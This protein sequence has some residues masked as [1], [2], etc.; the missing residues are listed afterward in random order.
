MQ[1]DILP[2]TVPVRASLSFDLAPLRAL[3]GDRCGA[4][5]HDIRQ[6]QGGQSNPTFLLFTDKGEYVLRKQPGGAL[7]PSA[8]AIDREYRIIEAL[9]HTDVPVPRPILYCNDRSV[10]GTPFYIME[11]LKGRG[12]A[13]PDL[14]EIG[15]AERHAIYEGMVDALAKLHRADWNALGLADYGK[16]E[17]YYARQISRWTKQ[18]NA[19][20]TRDN[21]SIDRLAEWLP[22]NIP[23]SNGTT[24]VHG[25]FKLDNMVFHATEPRVI[26]ILDWELSTLGDPMADLAYNCIPYLVEADNLR[27]LVGLDL[28][29]LGVP[30][31][32]AHIAAYFRRNSLRHPIQPFH[33][34]F[35]LFR[36]GVIIEGVLARA[37]A[38]NASNSNASEVGDRGLA[39]SRRGWDIASGRT[40]L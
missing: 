21:P 8:H 9:S 38:G 5:L 4:T 25:D 18:W 30:D 26:G 39:L 12:F 11:C 13:A 40:D 32:S 34:A 10:M 7:L 17:N 14:P 36:R 1:A 28:D 24:I 6:M 3:L 19:S 27:G 23:P 16:H 22:N 20:R 15:K 31:R 29:A 33:Y 37:K 2:A 35:A